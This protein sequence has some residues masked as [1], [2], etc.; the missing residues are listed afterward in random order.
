MGTFMYQ[1]GS[2]I[3]QGSIHIPPTSHPNFESCYL[4]AFPKSG[5]TLIN[6]LTIGLMEEAGV[7]II[8]L[9]SQLFVSGISINSVIANLDEIFRPRGYC[10]LGFRSV[11]PVMRGKLDLLTDRVILMV[12]DPRDMLVSLYYSLKYS[13]TFPMKSSPQFAYEK[14]LEVDKTCGSI[15]DFCVSS[16]GLYNSFLDDFL[17]LIS[18]RTVKIIRYEDIIFNKLSLA[19]SICDT[20]SLNNS[21]SR[22]QTLVSTFEVVPGHDKPGSHIRQVY[23]GDHRRKLTD[24]TIGILNDAMMKFL[25]AFDY[26]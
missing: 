16:I 20:F 10:Y 18:M 2:V 1:D 25:I 12:R 9:P 15:D 14:G 7:P 26:H 8:D 24:H 5:S 3:R 19:R 21:L 6:N 13:H 23:P 17:Q 4:F 11:L 22:L